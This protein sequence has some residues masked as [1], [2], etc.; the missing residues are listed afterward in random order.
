MT[1]KRA[2]M[3]ETEGEDGAMRDG[4]WMRWPRAITS[5]WTASWVLSLLRTYIALSPLEIRAKRA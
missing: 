1:T 4:V 2:R 3:R 5:C